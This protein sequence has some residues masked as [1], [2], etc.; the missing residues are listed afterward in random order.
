MDQA[1]ILFSLY[2]FKLAYNVAE[3]L[4]VN[5]CDAISLYNKTYPRGELGNRVV[6]SVPPSQISLRDI[7]QPLNEIYHPTTTDVVWN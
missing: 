2:K 7:F 6:R 5:S 3:K 1:Q 4:F